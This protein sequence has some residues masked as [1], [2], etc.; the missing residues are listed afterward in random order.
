MGKWADFYVITGSPLEDISNTR[1][2]H[3]VIKAG[4]V[5]FADKLL[6]SVLGKIGPYDK[7]DW[8]D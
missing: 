2:V 5:Y 8:Q 3:T 6:N 4:K 7:S 1:T